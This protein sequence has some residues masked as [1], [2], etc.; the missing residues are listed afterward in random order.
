MPKYNQAIQWK[1]MVFSIKRTLIATRVQ[2]LSRSAGNDSPSPT[3]HFVN[4][5]GESS[6]HTCDASRRE[7]QVLLLI[8]AIPQ[9]LGEHV[10]VYSLLCLFLCNSP[11][12]EHILCTR[13]LKCFTA[14]LCR[15]ID[16]KCS[17]PSKPHHIILCE[18][19]VMVYFPFPLLP[20]SP[21]R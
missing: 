14:G 2:P 12:S 16:Q 8:S 9:G 10:R 17:Y 4:H 6:K 5:S 11:L 18:K 21:S 15:H 13:L 7:F 3:T 19:S 20:P 1:H